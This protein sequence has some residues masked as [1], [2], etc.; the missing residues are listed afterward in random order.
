MSEKPT[1]VIIVDDSAFIRVLLTQ[2]LDSDDGIKVVG[3]AEDPFDARE[4]IKKYNPDVITLDVE[5][6]KMDGITFLK[7]LMR[8]R[9]MPVIMVSTLTQ[10]GAD[11]TMQALNAG[12]F[13]FVGKPSTEVKDKLMLL[14]EELIEKVKAAGRCNTNALEKTQVSNKEKLELKK[15]KSRVELIAIGASTGGTEA[16]QNVITRLPCNLPPIVMTQHIPDVFSTSYAK[17]LN[18][19][20]EMPIT[21]VRAPQLLERGHAYLAPGHMHMKVTRKQGQ[22]WAYLSDD[23]PV[24]RHKPAVD[25]LFDSVADTVGD[26]S[27]GIILTGMGADGAKGLLS[28]KNSGAFTVAQDEESSVVWGMPGAAVK[29]DAAEKVL[30]LSQ[31]PGYLVKKLL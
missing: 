4:K 15:G 28:L 25:V 1:T 19:E 18:G 21:E 27:I 30:S 29:L 17:R 14:S 23:S 9:P 7:N 5:M 16:I 6:P 13:D 2:I 20:A 8:L 31:I 24:N 11:I 26:K 10:A 12:A 3:T 22:L